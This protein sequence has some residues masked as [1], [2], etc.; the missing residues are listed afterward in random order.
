VLS[1]F[2]D[3]TRPLHSLPKNVRSDLG[4]KNGK[5]SEL[6]RNGEGGTS[7]NILILLAKN[8]FLGYTSFLTTVGHWRG[9]AWAT[10]SGAKRSALRTW[11]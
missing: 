8:S 11:Q 1:K 7:H 5:S 2:L 4:A 6:L 3:A 10:K 9:K